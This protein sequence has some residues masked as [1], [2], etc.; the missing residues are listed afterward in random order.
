MGIDRKISRR[1]A[2][3]IVLVGLLAMGLGLAQNVLEPEGSTSPPH[4][5]GVFQLEALL[6]EAKVVGCSAGDYL[7]DPNYWFD[8]SLVAMI[9]GVA[10]AAVGYVLSGMLGTPQYMAFVKDTIYGLVEG[11]VILGMF[12]ASFYGL[13][14]AGEYN[15]DSARAYSTVIRNTVVYDFGMMVVVSA[16]TSLMA[17]QAPQIRP[18]GSLP[19]FMFSFQLAPLFRPVF[20][21]LG[22]VLQLMTVS[23]VEWTAHEFFLCFIKTSMLS[24]LIPAGISLRILGIRNAANVLIALGF[25][26]YFVYP[27]LMNIVGESIS[28][29]IMEENDTLEQ[30]NYG[31]DPVPEHAL[32]GDPFMRPIK[33][34]GIATAQPPTLQEPFIPNGHEQD[35]IGNTQYRLSPVKLLEENGALLPY[36]LATVRSYCVYSTSLARTYS[37]VFH[38]LGGA[39]IALL[40]GGM[41]IGAL[42]Y[43]ASFFNVSYVFIAALIP[44]VA[45]AM[46]A[47]YETVFFVIIVSMVLPIF[48]IFITLT[49]AK[50]F[51]KLLGTEIDLSAIEKIL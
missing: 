14:Q 22:M 4:Q 15:L 8:L 40:A 42:S 35:W 48:M 10:I 25:S 18:V 26:L 47:L 3:A 49:I 17:K 5:P 38:K 50:E 9:L 1:S 19:G 29:Y 33:C 6:G 46:N 36:N 41:G 21:L 51:A 37:F 31:S 11:A 20:D 12:G 2:L 27:W 39:G 44:M 34:V 28:Y 23:M 24:L 30:V 45:F 43:L 16:L 7:G 32:G 13:K